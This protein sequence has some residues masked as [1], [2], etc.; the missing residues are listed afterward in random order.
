MTGLI[1]LLIAIYRKNARPIDRPLYQVKIGQRTEWITPD[2]WFKRNKEHYFYL[3]QL[4]VMKNEI[5]ERNLK[6]TN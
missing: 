2:E 5:A 6:R 1:Y 4:G 3:N